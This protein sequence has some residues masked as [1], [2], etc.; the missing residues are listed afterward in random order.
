MTGADEPVIRVL[1]VDDVLEVRRDLRTAL[2]LAGNIEVVGEA[3]NGLEAVNLAQS[4][5]PVVVLMD[6]K[7]PV[8]DGYEA[9]RWIKAQ[10][11]TPRVV[12]LSIHAG[13][14]EEERARAAGADAF[15]VKGDSYQILLNAILGAV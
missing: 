11:P 3:T 2:T 7:M 1:I 12:I 4:L 13:A 6:L 15:V 14:G 8:M 5:E 10:Q 9:T